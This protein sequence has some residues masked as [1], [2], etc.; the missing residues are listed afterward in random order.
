VSA[1]NAGNLQRHRERQV[2]QRDQQRGL[3]NQYRHL[4]HDAGQSGEKRGRLRDLF[5]H[6]FWF[7]AFQLR[8][9]PQWHAAG[10]RDGQQRDFCFSF[11]SQRR[12]LC[13]NRLRG[14]QQRSLIAPL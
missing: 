6:G 1:T 5:H 11:R 12:N 4:R 10:G 9:E 14:V 7:G 2:Q 8:L 13:R 3:D